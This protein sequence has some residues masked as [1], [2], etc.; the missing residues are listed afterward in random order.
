MPIP[1]SIP[2]P[3]RAPATGGAAAD[4]ARP[5]TGHLV[6]AV[7]T[8]ARTKAGT[9]AVTAADGAITYDELADRA[10]AIAER[11][12]AEG[13]GPGTAVA[14]LTGRS[15]LSTPSL[16]AVW[17]LGATAVLADERHPADRI[18]LVL[19]DA[20]A[21][22]V[23][24]GHVPA[25]AVPAKTT[26]IDPG[27][28]EL[29]LPASTFTPAVPR[30]QDCAYIVYT[31]GTTGWP[32]GV[33]VS[34]ANLDTFLTALGTLDFP[35]GGT[36]VNAVS[37]SFD[38][39]LWCTML[40]LTYG[41]TMAI[42]DLAARDAIGLAEMIEVHEPRVLCLTPTLLSALER[43]PAAEA[44]VVAGEPC[45][46]SLVARLADVPRVLNVYGPTEGTIAATCADSRRGDDLTT[47]GRPL[48]GYRLRVLNEHRS[49]VAHGT[50]GELYICGPAVA[51]GY[52]N[53]PELTEERFVPDHIAADG[54][55][56]YR[57][58]DLAR[59]RRDG[60][61]EFR[62]RADDQVKVRGYRVELG[63]IER[64]ALSVTGV[65]AAAAFTSATGDTLGL[66]VTLEPGAE[67]HEL[68]E[69]LRHRCAML[70]PDFMVPAI[71]TVVA[72][73]PSLPTG[74]VD[75]GA[76]ARTGGP[77]AG[78]QAPSTDRERQVCA[79]WAELLKR[80][81]EDVTASFFELGGHS[82]LAARAVGALR[83][84]TGLP[85]SVH[86]LLLDPTAASLAR[87]MDQLATQAV[88]AA[89][90]AAEHA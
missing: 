58:G 27:G 26:L 43:V 8:W 73:L 56:M 46:P 7:A 54:S 25:G 37:P 4:T 2:V 34:Y 74:K 21:R 64:I 78:G 6:E 13:V 79:A 66:G 55:R 23:L 1:T 49:P 15:R 29:S 48:P 24:A 45:P 67:P 82:L 83:R 85:L 84:S 59:F 50:E 51:L 39:W 88:T 40:Y 89:P 44:I 10:A 11:L 38:G 17:W 20:G 42:V 72:V 53:R 18:N 65:R 33:E 63:E 3:P 47:I 87:E 90:V 52:R 19:R 86:H 57:T 41:Q 60:Q 62:G 35:S 80:P 61:Y 75:R 71:V 68:T 81:V 32:K 9:P 77:A 14:L 36:G 70:L 69:R 5:G 28:L 30:P 22:I 12:R 76:L 16:L 31:S